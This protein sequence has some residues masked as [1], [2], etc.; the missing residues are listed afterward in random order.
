MILL[1]MLAWA[2]LRLP[3]M[4]RSLWLVVLLTWALGASGMTW[5]NTKPTWLLFADYCSRGR[6]GSIGESEESRGRPGVYCEWLASKLQSC[7]GSYDA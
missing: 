4:E 2:T 5:E 6:C 7:S 1:G 3:L